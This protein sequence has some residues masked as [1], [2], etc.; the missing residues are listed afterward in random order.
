MKLNF[1]CSCKSLKFLDGNGMQVSLLNSKL[2]SSLAPLVPLFL[3]H[4][5]HLVKLQSDD[6]EEVVSNRLTNI[7]CYRFHACLYLTAA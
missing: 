4:D 5:R 2:G 6:F 7:K 3:R 1:L